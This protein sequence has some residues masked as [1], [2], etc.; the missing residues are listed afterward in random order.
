M[1]QLIKRG[2]SSFSRSPLSFSSRGIFTTGKQ[3]AVKSSFNGRTAF[4]TASMML[5]GSASYMYLNKF[6]TM[7]L[8]SLAEAQEQNLGNQQRLHKKLDL[9]LHFTLD[10]KKQIL[11]IVYD[12]SNA[13]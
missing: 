8:P 3:N 9:N 2:G 1:K 7:S 10:A 6:N 13:L 11:F 4:L 5:V 12:S